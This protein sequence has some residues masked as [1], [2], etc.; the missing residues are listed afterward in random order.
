MSDMLRRRGSIS[1]AVL[2]AALACA[3]ALF[4]APAWAATGSISGT[5]LTREGNFPVEEVRVCAWDVEEEHVCEWTQGDGTYTIA[6]LKA[7]DYKVEFWPADSGQDLALQ[8]YDGKSRWDD[9][10]VISLAEGEE[11]TGLDV[12]LPPGS[13]I[14][15]NVYDAARQRPVVGARVCSIDALTDRLWI[16]TR[17]NE[18]GNYELP[19]HAAGEYKVAFS[20]EL[21]EWVP[22][23]AAEDDGYPTQFWNNASS[24]SGAFVISL[25][26]SWRAGAIDARY[27]TPPVAAPPAI[28]LPAKPPPRKPLKCKR[29]YRKKLVRGK[30]RCARVHR[31]HRHHR[32]HGANRVFRPV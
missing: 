4:A 27:G 11:R 18:A 15:G 9:A 10:D 32:N 21:R 14:S 3:M 26:T 25:G 28:A 2:F 7:G 1:A 17:S 31:K 12:E 30:R 20:L 19:F 24:L 22:G 8:F 29:G 16:C 23:A 13:T 6:E 5:V